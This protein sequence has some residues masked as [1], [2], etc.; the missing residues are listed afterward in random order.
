M[1]PQAL[2]AMDRSTPTTNDNHVFL[3]PLLLVLRLP[4]ALA[5]LKRRAADLGLDLAQRSRDDNFTVLD[6]G[7]IR[8][9]AVE[10]RGVLD[11]TSGEVE[12]GLWSRLR[13]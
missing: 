3:L 6:F 12:A 4:D 13:S 10:T 8:E 1:L 2:Q 11:V 7:F 9:Q 5:R